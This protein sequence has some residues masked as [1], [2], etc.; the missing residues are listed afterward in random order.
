MSTA[1]SS[2]SNTESKVDTWIDLTGN[3]H[4]TFGQSTTTTTTTTTTPP[5][6]PLVWR[7]TGPG[8]F[9]VTIE[10]KEKK[11]DDDS[12]IPGYPQGPG[13]RPYGLARNNELCGQDTHIKMIF[14]DIPARVPAHSN[15]DYGSID[16][17]PLDI[18]ELSA[19]IGFARKLQREG[20]SSWI[21]PWVVDE[22]K[23]V[24]V[25][26]HSLYM[27]QIYLHWPLGVKPPVD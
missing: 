27:N 15:G 14:T 13:I 4:P 9:V 19:M 24:Q 22:P 11:T 3:V 2:S 25:Y 26:C 5:A 23:M 6:T 8:T 18:L 21:K 17:S 20:W 7:T 16:G 10:E 1:S 12:D